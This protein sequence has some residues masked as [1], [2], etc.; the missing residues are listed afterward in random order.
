MKRSFAF[1]ILFFGFSNSIQAQTPTQLEQIG[2]LLE[3]ALLYSKQY[4]IPATDG[5]VYQASSAWMNSAKKKK[6]W[7][8]LVGIHA[9]TFKVPKSDRSFT[10]NNSD[11]KFLQ[12]EGTATSAEVPT[13]L[14]NDDTFVLV[15]DLDGQEVRLKTPKGVNQEYITYPYLDVAFALPSGTEVIGR[16][17]TKTKLKR[18]DY[19]VYG[20]GLKHNLSQYFPRLES[21][22]IHVSA[23]SFYSNED[24]SFD[25]LDVNTSFGNLGINNL[26]GIV[27]TYHYQLSV[28]KEIK[29]FEI[30]GSFIVNTSDF[31]YIVS[32]EKGEIENVLPVQQIIN[33]LL[34]TIQKRKTNYIGE[35][36]V[37][38]GFKNFN[39]LSAFAFGKFMNFNVGVSYKIN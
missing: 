17:S 38:Y 20:F 37:N 22:K 13:A 6:D 35:V 8:I 31:N 19:Q 5:A 23:M 14:G 15:G 26:N 33:Q 36:A 39:I 24:I 34:D 4:L 18:G 28:S 9:N 30:L 21:N 29:R 10:I 3:D 12:L 25:F 11:F 32:G 2:Y 7:E 27:D 16:F 1:C